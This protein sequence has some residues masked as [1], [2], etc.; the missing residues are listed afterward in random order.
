MSL[1]L[2]RCAWCGSAPLD[3]DPLYTTSSGGTAP[4]EHVVDYDVFC[5]YFYAKKGGVAVKP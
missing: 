3:T 2:V 1:G 5:G 4:R